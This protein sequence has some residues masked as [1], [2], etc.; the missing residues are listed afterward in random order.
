M[1]CPKCNSKDIR[2]LDSRPEPK[3]VRRRRFCNSCNHR[4]STIERL[5]EVPKQR[6]PAV[7]RTPTTPKIRKTKKYNEWRDVDHMT[8]EELEAMIMDGD[9][10]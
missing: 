8:D 10:D 4:F 6:K 2:V 7:K 3:L 9:Y 5:A 1:Q